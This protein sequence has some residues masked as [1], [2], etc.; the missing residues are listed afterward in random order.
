MTIVGEPDPGGGRPGF[1]VEFLEAG[2]SLLTPLTTII[3]AIHLAEDG[4]LGPVTK[5]QQDFLRSA[6]EEAQRLSVR[7]NQLLDRAKAV[8][9]DDHRGRTS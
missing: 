6:R 9:A 7:L 2:H 3:E 5:E 4:A 1:S 8:A